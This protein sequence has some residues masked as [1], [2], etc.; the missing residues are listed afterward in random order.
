MRILV[1]DDEPDIRE[2][3]RDLLEALV[4]AEVHVARDG[5]QGLEALRRQAFDA[6]VTDERMPNMLGSEMLQA[7]GDGAP[8]VRVLITAYAHGPEIAQRCGATHFLAKPLRPDALVRILRAP[9][10]A[11]PPAAQA[12][13]G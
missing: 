9:V 11:T 1:V 6:V 12:T 8:P 2:A 5:R 4:P 3:L 10:P 13:A 7:L